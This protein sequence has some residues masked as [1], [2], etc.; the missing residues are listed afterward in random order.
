MS[1]N[2]ARQLPGGTPTPSRERGEMTREDFK[3]QKCFSTHQERYR[4]KKL[5]LLCLADSNKSIEAQSETARVT[6]SHVKMRLVNSRNEI[7]VAS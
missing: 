4:V 3:E 5:R 6:E 7:L 1:V 2:T